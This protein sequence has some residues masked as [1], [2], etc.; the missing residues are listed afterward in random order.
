M[1][2]PIKQHIQLIMTMKRMQAEP[3]EC[4]VEGGQLVDQPTPGQSTCL[5]PPSKPEINQL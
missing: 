1:D 2:W 5:G 4:G 3:L